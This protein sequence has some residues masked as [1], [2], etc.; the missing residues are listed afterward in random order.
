M[1][2]LE[3]KSLWAVVFIE[4]LMVSNRP[5]RNEIVFLDDPYRHAVKIPEITRRSR[6]KD[7]APP[8]KS[9][10]KRKRKPKFKGSKAARKAG[11]RK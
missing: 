11:R 6:V 2:S 7:Y 10:F 5:D 3:E 4:E 1:M 9:K 8:E